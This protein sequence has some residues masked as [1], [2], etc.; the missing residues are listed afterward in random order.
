ML[1]PTFFFNSCAEGRGGGG[2]RV[3]LGSV[4]GTGAVDGQEAKGAPLLQ[5]GLAVFHS[6][7]V[8]GTGQSGSLQHCLIRQRA[9]VGIHP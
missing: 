2:L 9:D 5:D 7:E 8:V 4:V 3:E 6:Q 1:V